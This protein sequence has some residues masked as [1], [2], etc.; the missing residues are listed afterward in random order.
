LIK[1]RA[2]AK[3]KQVLV[4]L[5]KE[6]A[7]SPRINGVSTTREISPSKKLINATKTQK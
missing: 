5:K 1:L 2:I 7:S 4:N 6:F 3:N